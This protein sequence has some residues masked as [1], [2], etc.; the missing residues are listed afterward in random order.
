MKKEALLHFSVLV[1]YFAL[2]TLY[3]R[4]FDSPVYLLFWVGGIVGTL[5]P[6]F[7]HLIYSYISRP[8]DLTSQRAQH[9]FSAKEITKAG[10]LLAMT[11]YE[12]V[13]PIFHTAF[14]QVFFAIFSFFVITS[15][16]SLLGRGLVLAFLLHLVVDQTKDYLDTD[17][18]DRWFYNLKLK[19]TSQT[20]SFYLLANFLLIAFFGLFF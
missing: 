6:D 14:F 10:N 16:G 9:M 3:K 13:S 19:P 7:D 12:R 11:R 15:T 4:W 20:T 17:S 2:I 5:L 18:L 8:Q 1:I